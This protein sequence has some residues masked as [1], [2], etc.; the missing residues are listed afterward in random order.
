[1][2]NYRYAKGS[3]LLDFLGCFPWDFIYK[4]SYIQSKPYIHL[5]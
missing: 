3:F 4:V 5:T 2:M 1:M